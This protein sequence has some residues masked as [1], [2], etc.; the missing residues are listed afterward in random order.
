MCGRFRTWKYS[1]RERKGCAKRA[2]SLR[3]LAAVW[4]GSAAGFDSLLRYKLFLMLSHAFNRFLLMTAK[5]VS[6]HAVL[7]ASF[8]IHNVIFYF[9]STQRR[10]AVRSA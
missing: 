3:Q 6:V 7:L 1:R 8:Q 2:K 5:R 4:I 9:L 10:A